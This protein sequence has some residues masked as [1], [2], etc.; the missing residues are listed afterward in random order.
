MVNRVLRV[1]DVLALILEISEVEMGSL[2]ACFPLICSMPF[3]NLVVQ[4]LRSQLAD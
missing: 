1:P 4:L 3:F 2:K